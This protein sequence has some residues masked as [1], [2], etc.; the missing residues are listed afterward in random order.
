MN[1][2]GNKRNFVS[3]KLK[4]KSKNKISPIIYKEREHLEVNTNNYENE[5]VIHLQEE[6]KEKT[7]FKEF[8]S[9]NDLKKGLNPQKTYSKL[10]KIEPLPKEYKVYKKNKLTNFEKKH[11]KKL[12]KDKKKLTT[13]QKMNKWNFDANYEKYQKLLTSIPDFNE[14]PRISGA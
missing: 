11:L 5:S 12:E 9:E 8:V 2:L 6:N 4:F 14:M 1:L 3:S 13:E 7:I 10:S